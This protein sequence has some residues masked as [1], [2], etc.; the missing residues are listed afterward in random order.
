MGQI[1]DRVAAWAPADI[2]LEEA[3]LKAAKSESNSLVVAGPGA[4]KTELLAQRACF[5]LQTG[6]CPP[7][8]RILAISFKRDAA[9]NLKR[10]VI[11]RCGGDLAR[12]LDSLTYDAFAKD[13]LDRFRLSLPKGLLPT[14]D[15]EIVLGADVS[16]ARLHEKML[17]LPTEVLSLTEHQRQL[18]GPAALR[19][20]ML[21]RSLPFANWPKD[22]RFVAAA[23]M[24]SG[25]LR[26][27]PSRL[28]FTMINRLAEFL[29]RQN[30]SIRAAMRETY[31]FVFLDEFQDTTTLQCELMETCF[32][33]STS[34]LTAV[35]DTKQKIM[36]WAGALTGIFGRFEKTFKADVVRLT[37][38]HRSRSR[39]V[40]VQS[41]FAAELDAKAVPATTS[42]T[43]EE[44]G[45]CRVL[46]F[47]DQQ[48]EST[49]LAG[50]I[51]D[52]ITDKEI[53]AEEICVLCRALPAVFAKPLID[54][55]KDRGVKVILDV[56]RRDTLGEPVAGLLLDML[57]LMHSESAPVAW[58]HVGAIASELRGD[59]DDDAAARTRR[60][61]LAFL[62]E[63]KATMPKQKA[64]REEI[65]GV[66]NACLDFI[67]RDRFA[68]RHPQYAQ[69]DYLKAVLENLAGFIE[70]ELQHSAWPDIPNAV[71][72]IGAVSV[73]TMHKSKGLEFDTVI[74]L[75]LEDRAI[76]SYQKNK[77]EETCGLFVALS[78]A[79]DRC[80]FTFCRTRVDKNGA[81]QS[82]TRITIARVFELFR[83][84]GV[85]VERI[86]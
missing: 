4:G 82:Q 39:L 6:L 27:H 24:W 74:F 42:R 46:E 3:A 62:D 60:K 17:H 61:L 68:I 23:G 51:V 2:V 10:R 25:M 67:G 32:Y 83:Q 18:V 47:S 70:E 78:R 84:S 75:G 53:A 57:E 21:E 71:R 29:V 13:L 16:D 76:W 63:K 59:E 69:G 36:G 14:S 35:G 22:L 34:V 28:M 1:Q 41:V 54:A 79:K 80:I 77:D 19:L 44:T 65:L 66:L 55:L 64:P 85:T 49:F 43:G 20:G 73:M 72:G 8:Y 11:L 5:L 7:P 81:E 40:H 26:D 15:Y 30:P 58:E 37:Q 31:R 56:N 86:D 12:R 9:E 33:G 38:N 52:L 45:E 48:S 50:T